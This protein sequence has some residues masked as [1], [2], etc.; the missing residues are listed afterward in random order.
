MQEL[1]V[2]Q[3]TRLKNFVIYIG[4]KLVHLLIVLLCLYII[5]AADL[6]P[7]VTKIMLTSVL[8]EGGL[9]FKA[10]QIQVNNSGHSVNTS[11]PNITVKP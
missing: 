11:L 4:E 1:T 8:G 9:N 3:K 2:N 10:A 6:P 7:H 5:F